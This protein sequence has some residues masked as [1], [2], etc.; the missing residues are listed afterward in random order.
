MEVKTLLKKFDFSD[1][2]ID[3]Y[4]GM[5]QLGPAVAS[6]IAK[7]AGINRSTTYVIL[8]M[9][10]KRGVVTSSE[11]RGEKMYNPLSPDQLAKHFGEVAKQYSDLA[12]EAKRVL[13]KLKVAPK[14]EEAMPKIS[15]Y[16]GDQ[17]IKSVYE[18]ALGS[19]ETIRTFASSG[20]DSKLRAS[21]QEIL[22]KK[23]I[24]VRLLSSDKKNI[25]SAEGRGSSVLYGLAPEISVYDNKVVFVS[26]KDKTALI[27]ENKEFAQALKKAFDASWQDKKHPGGASAFSK[28]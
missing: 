19:L 10:A 22:A 6:D 13:P 25:K 5:L 12:N 8:D 23:N 1:K 2:E 16:Q 15:F 4:L 28:A 20:Q 7:N 21:Y 24:R 17:G 3:V 26:A 18:D 11:R 14:K 9:L 27:I